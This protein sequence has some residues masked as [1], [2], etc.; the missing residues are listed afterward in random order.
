[1]TG[2]GALNS[3]AVVENASDGVLVG[4]FDDKAGEEYFMVVNLAC[5]LLKSKMDTARTVRLT[6]APGDHTPSALR[7]HHSRR[8]ADDGIAP[9]V[10]RAE[11][12]GV[13]RHADLHGS[14]AD[15]LSVLANGDAKQSDQKRAL[16]IDTFGDAADAYQSRR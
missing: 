14:V 11:P 15:E 6:F 4:F 7:G 3:V 9:I 16:C 10:D 5:G 12:S 2:H 13:E 1:M 8:H